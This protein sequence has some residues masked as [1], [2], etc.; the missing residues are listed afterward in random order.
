M[1]EGNRDRVIGLGN[2]LMADDGLGV[3]V[4]ELLVS[5]RFEPPVEFVDGGTWGMNLLPWIEESDRVL[6][7]DAVDLGEKPGTVICLR[8][9]D[10]PRCR[11]LRISPH[12]VDL[13]EVLSVAELRGRLPREVV[14]LGAQP[15]VVRLE[16]GLSSSVAAAIPELTAWCLRLLESWGHKSVAEQ[17]SLPCTS[18]A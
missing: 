18:P 13:R 16:P 7:I 8:G 17:E 9:L 11:V 1:I 2:P 5:R 14:L 15:E 12:Q 3:K 10:F 4:L 6:F